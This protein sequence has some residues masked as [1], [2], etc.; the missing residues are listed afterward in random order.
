[1]KRLALLTCLGFA[2]LAHAQAERGGY[3]GGSVGIFDYEEAPTVDELAFSDDP[4]IYHIFGGYQLNEHVAIE[5]GFGRTGDIEGS[6]TDIFPG[7]TVEVDAIY[8]I[9][10]FKVLG[11]LPFDAVSLF[12]AAG[13]YSASLSGPVEV[14]NFGQIGELDGHERGATATIGVQKDF[15]LDLRSMSL[16]AQLDWYDFGSEIDA[17]GFTIGMVWRF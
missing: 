9:Y 14:V 12:G 10:T 15:G 4:W 2:Q 5:A 8:D 3:M 1:M 6:F 16:R 7:F 17:T 13:Y 11:I